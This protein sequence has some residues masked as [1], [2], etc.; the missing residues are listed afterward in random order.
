MWAVDD[1]MLC[2]F[3]WNPYGVDSCTLFF[4]DMQPLR[5]FEIKCAGERKLAKSDKIS[6]QFYVLQN[7]KSPE[8]VYGL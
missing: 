8:K 7:Q 2:A 1:V 5:G 4:I 6:R 3:Q